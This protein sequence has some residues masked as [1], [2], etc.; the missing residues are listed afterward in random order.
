M[1]RQRVTGRL[2]VAKSSLPPAARREVHFFHGQPTHVCAD[3]ADLQPP[4]LLVQ[5]DLVKQ[6]QLDDCIRAVIA[7]RR[8]LE[9]MLSQRANLDVDRCRAFVMTLRLETIFKWSSGHFAFDAAHA[10][11]ST[12]PFA[13]SIYGLLPLIVDRTR[14]NRELER[15]VTPY[16][17][18]AYS[19]SSDFEAVIGYLNLS[20]AELGWIKSSTSSRPSAS[21]CCRRRSK[22]ARRWCSRT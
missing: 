4:H 21:G 19:K 14:S 2:V 1:A 3:D 16:L 11:K 5:H 20:A 22:S 15:A 10:P 7:E 9:F 17:D 13:T 8:P 12:R 6:D 18:C